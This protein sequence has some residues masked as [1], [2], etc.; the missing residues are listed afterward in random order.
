MNWCQHERLQPLVGNISWSLR[1]GERPATVNRHVDAFIRCI[2][3]IVD[4]RGNNPEKLAAVAA[5]KHVAGRPA[6][7]YPPYLI[8]SFQTIAADLERFVKR[9]PPGQDFFRWVEGRYMT[10]QL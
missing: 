5:M 3:E 6:D 9:P 2:T 8:R 7:R 4:C 10:V 1:G